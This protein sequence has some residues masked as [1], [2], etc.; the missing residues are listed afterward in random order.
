[1]KRVIGLGIAALIT[2]AGPA[3]AQNDKPKAPAPGNA[4]SQPGKPGG[5]APE[6]DPMM[7]A[8]MKAAQPGP[9][10]AA[11]ARIAGTWDAVVKMYEPGVDKP[12]ESK[13][14]MTN[15]L[16][17]G[18]RYVQMNYKGEMMGGEFTGSGV[19]G[20]D[21]LT[22]KYFSTWCDN[23]STGIM[24]MTGT[25]DAASKTYTSTGEM[26]MPMPDGTVMKMNQRETVKIV[27]DDKHIMEMYGPGPDGKEMKHMEI[28]YTRRK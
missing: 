17:H 10:H 28:T 25:Y 9:E 23:W 19:W 5:N 27:S 6:A 20:Y 13:G 22:K 8:M 1:M 2:M 4:P 15:T 21:N 12:E 16:I 14:V 11:M 18:G 7:E 24:M 26:A 3:L